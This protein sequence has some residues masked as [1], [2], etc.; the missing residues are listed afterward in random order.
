MASLTLRMLNA[1]RQPLDDQVDVDV[2]AV[3]TNAT[4]WQK[5]GTSGKTKI[6]VTG[7]TAGAPY[8]IR[9]FPVR[10]RPVGQ[11]ALAS[12]NDQRPTVVELYCPVHPLRVVEP[13]YPAYGTLDQP[14]RTVLE[15]STLETPAG[16]PAP[17]PPPGK[18]QGES[19]YEGLDALQKAG[20]LNLWCKMSQ[21]AIGNA[22][23]WAF[24]NDL[25]RVRGDRVFANVR[26]DFRDQV[27]NAVAGTLFHDVPE[28]Q[29]NPGPGFAHAGS[30]KTPERYG[31]LQLTFFASVDAPLRFQ[32][33]ADIDDAGG[34][35]HAFQ[36]LEHFLTGGE[37]H[38]YDIH[39]ILTFYQGLTPGYT[40]R[41]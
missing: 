40:L 3:R 15:R 11:F 28:S 20:L 4:A 41:V 26:I 17:V 13:M 1:Q 14:L 34:I 38:P 16:T 12:Q 31:N 32:L 21:T 5:R 6:Q 23:T 25:Y 2:V 9:V 24:V 30:F 27:K 39:E 22:S 7:L 18:T 33:D 37:T 10:H 36:V 29:H 8:S 35:G 19:L